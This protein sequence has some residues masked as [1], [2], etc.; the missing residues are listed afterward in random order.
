MSAQGR[1]S[2]LYEGLADQG[3]LWADEAP[4][5]VRHEAVVIGVTTPIARVDQKVRQMR[6]ISQIVDDDQSVHVRP[7][8]RFLIARHRVIV[9][10]QGVEPLSKQQLFSRAGA[11]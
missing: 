1:R 7:E 8:A 5:V 9:Q 11:A 6:P 10:D 3:V 4:G 2:R